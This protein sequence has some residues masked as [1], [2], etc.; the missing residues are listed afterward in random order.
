MPNYRPDGCAVL[1]RNV[2]VFWKT[3]NVPPQREWNNSRHVK[4]GKPGNLLGLK[5]KTGFREGRLFRPASL[6]DTFSR[7]LLREAAQ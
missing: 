4:T 1:C 3:T 7:L 2:V 5:R 6:V